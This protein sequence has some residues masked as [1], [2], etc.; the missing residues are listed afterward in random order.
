MGTEEKE[1]KKKGKI[2]SDKS[3]EGNSEEAENAKE[4]RRIRL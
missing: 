4:E 2:Q 3:K 1:G